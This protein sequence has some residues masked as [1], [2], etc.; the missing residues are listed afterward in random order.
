MDNTTLYIIIA[1]LGGLVT[2]GFFALLQKLKTSKK[3]EV[4]TGELDGK[5]IQL[6]ELKS[7]LAEEESQFELARK[8][9]ETKSQQL[10]KEKHDLKQE[11]SELKQKNMELD[12][13]LKEGQP[14]IHSLKLKLIEAN[15]NI[16]RYKGKYG[17]L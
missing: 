17:S 1:A 16:A 12:Q 14:V 15:N 7:K 4:L 3:E 13:L 2:G 11:V 8:N 10:E 5:K 9:F 6:H